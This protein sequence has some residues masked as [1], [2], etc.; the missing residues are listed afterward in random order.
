MREKYAQ[1]MADWQMN[2][3]AQDT[4]DAMNIIEEVQETLKKKVVA[5]I[6]T[7]RIK[8]DEVFNVVT[9]VL[10]TY[11]VIHKKGK[12]QFSY[13]SKFMEYDVVIFQ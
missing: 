5:S 13:Q 8:N 4:Y 1:I 9:G 11:G 3:R 12:C 10:F 2:G 6:R 7:S